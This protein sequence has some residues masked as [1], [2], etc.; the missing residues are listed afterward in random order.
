MQESTTYTDQTRR[1]REGRERA[2]FIGDLRALAAW[3]EE[4]PDVPVPAPMQV[5]APVSPGPSDD[6]RRAA[7]DT[8]AARHRTEAVTGGG[9]YGATVRFGQVSYYRYYIAA[10]SR[11]ATAAVQSYEPNLRLAVSA[12]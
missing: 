11:A 10:E 3:L 5:L 4:H 8:F 1:D 2:G 9:S 7:V 12:A 6:A